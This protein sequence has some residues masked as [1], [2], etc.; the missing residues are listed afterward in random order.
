MILRM[1]AKAKYSKENIG[2]Y[3][4]ASDCY[5]HFTSPIRRYP[6]LL[7]HRLIR[8]YLIDNSNFYQEFNDEFEIRL[9]EKIASIAEHSSEME[10]N[11]ANCEYEVRDMK[12]A[13]YME[14][15]IGEKF[16]GRISSVTN[17]GMFVCI[18]DVIEGLVHIRDIDDDYYVYD[19]IKMALVGR[20]TSKKYKMGDTVEV[21][22]VNAN[23]ETKEIDFKLSTNKNKFRDSNK[24][25]NVLKY[26]G[27]NANSRGEKHGK[28]RRK[29]GHR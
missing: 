18:K 17:F 24:S 22:C 10:V 19:E 20:R 25:K 2:H 11:A 6:D 3:G 9:S 7:V 4:L 5:T 8:M 14:N 23:K 13:E 1:M 27:K 29:K 12:I 26:S 15:H 16:K 21:I 28:K